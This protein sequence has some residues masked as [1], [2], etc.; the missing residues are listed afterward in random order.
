MADQELPSID[1]VLDEARRTIDFQFEQLDGLDTKS[2]IV[3][4]IAGVILALLVTSLL[5]QSNTMANSLLVKV[6]LVPIFL[7]LILSFI[8]ICVRK[9]DKPPQ[10]ERLR[11][12][13]ITQPADETKLRIIDISVN[14]MEK[15]DKRIKVRV[16][17]LKSSYFVLAI[18]LGLLA[19]WIGIVVWQ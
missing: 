13:Y 12:H 18:G 16:R 17:L 8:S 11:S 7:S 15:N 10:L 1:V 4:G 5:E 3:L 19:V 9:W 2:G 14:A 6:A